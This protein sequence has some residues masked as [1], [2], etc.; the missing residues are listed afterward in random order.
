MRFADYKIATFCQ[1]HNTPLVVLFAFSPVGSQKFVTPGAPHINTQQ[2]ALLRY[3][4]WGNPC[5][6]PVEGRANRNAAHPVGLLDALDGAYGIPVTRWRSAIAPLKSAARIISNKRIMILDITATNT[7]TDDGMI[8]L[9]STLSPTSVK[10]KFVGRKKT[11][12]D[13]VPTTTNSRRHS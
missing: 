6:E 8:A 4:H 9:S 2:G 10:P 1:D 11:I 3:H 5:P 13:I 12:T 7:A